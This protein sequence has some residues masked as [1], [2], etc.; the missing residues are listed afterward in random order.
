MNQQQLRRGFPDGSAASK[1]TL[2][3]PK[4][5]LDFRISVDLNPIIPVGEGPW[6]KRNWISFSGGQWSASWGH[7]MV[8]PGGQDSQLVSPDTLQT[9]VSTNY[10]LRT[11]D[12]KPAY[13]TVQTTG[14]RTGSKEVL[15]KLFDPDQANAVKPSDYS[16]RLSIKLETGDERYRDIVN[17][18]LWVGSGARR[19]SQVIYDAYRVQ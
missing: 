18:G 1:M 8:E 7:G 12:A 5:D 10:L 11:A 6:G 17:S 4:L 9:Y 15:E 3:V 16:F 2:P 13:I 19:G 14:W